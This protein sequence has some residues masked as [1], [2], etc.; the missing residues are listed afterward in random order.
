MPGAGKPARRANVGA[1]CLVQIIHSGQEARPWDF[2]IRVRMDRKVLKEA[3]WR[4]LSAE[5]LR[6]EPVSLALNDSRKSRSS[7]RSPVARMAL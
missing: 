1:S 2:S 7:A 4:A 3:A 5:I 6:K